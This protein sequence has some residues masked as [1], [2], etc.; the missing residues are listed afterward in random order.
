M[1]HDMASAKPAPSAG[2]IDRGN[3]R[4]RAVARGVEEFAYRAIV[5]RVVARLVNEIDA[6]LDVGARRE[7]VA[8]AGEDHDAHVVAIAECVEQPD[9]FLARR[10][11]LRIH[12]RPVE[13]DGG[14]VVG[15][16]EAEVFKVHTL[17]S[18]NGRSDRV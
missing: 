7:H 15:N 13:D 14:D 12:R 16:V 6:L 10:A 5:F 8:D 9:E 17:L 4:T 18:R 3:H 11:A 1:S 2:P